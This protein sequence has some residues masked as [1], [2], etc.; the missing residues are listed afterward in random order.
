[1]EHHYGVQDV[2]VLTNKGARPNPVHL[3]LGDG[4]GKQI[5]SDYNL[6]PHTVVRLDK[7]QICSSACPSNK[8]DSATQTIL[9][10]Y[11]GQF[12]VLNP[13][14]LIYGCSSITAD[15]K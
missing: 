9:D 13:V 12:Y 3:V 15:G 14:N 1:M 4:A 10:S 2:L 11:V 5:V 7:Y 6:S 8:T